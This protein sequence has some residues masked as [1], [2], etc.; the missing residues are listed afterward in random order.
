MGFTITED[1][2][3][4]ILKVPAAVWTPAYDAGGQMRPG[5]WVAEIYRHA[6]PGRLAEGDA[7]HRPHGAP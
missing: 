1:I 6:H 3:D 4:A 7:G 5:A 2:Q